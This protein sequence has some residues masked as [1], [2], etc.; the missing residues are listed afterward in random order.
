M[1]L[2]AMD[3]LCMTPNTKQFHVPAMMREL[4]KA[5]VAFKD[6]EE[7]SVTDHSK[8]TRRPVS[9]GN[10]GC[11]TFGGDPQLKFILQWMAC[12]VAGRD[13]VYT[14]HNDPR[15]QPHV[16]AVAAMLRDMPVGDVWAR[17]LPRDAE[18]F[19]FG[20]LL[21]EEQKTSESNQSK[22]TVC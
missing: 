17:L 8:E 19:S 20:R 7:E 16:G 9:T 3:A 21:S 10:W 15:I 22:C 5:Y 4:V 2:V 1:Q 12:T 11:G 6:D 13:M 14:T 18:E